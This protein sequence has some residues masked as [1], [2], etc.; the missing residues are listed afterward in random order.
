MPQASGL[1]SQL[2]LAKESTYGTRVAPTKAYEFDS[3]TFGADY[4]SVQGGGLRAGRTMA[5]ASMS[6]RTTDQAA[7]AFTLQV[8]YKGFG[9]ILDLLHNAV[10]TPVQQAATIA[11]KQTH[12]IGV[13]TGTSLSKSA[14]IQINKPDVTG[15]DRPFDYVGSVVTQ[16]ELA[17]SVGGILSSTVTCDARQ[18]MTDQTLAVPSYATGNN[19][20]SFREA[21]VMTLDGTNLGTATEFNLSLGRGMK[22]DRFYLGSGGLKAVPIANSLIEGSGTINVDFNDLAALNLY[23]S[24][25]KVPLVVEFVSA[26]DIVAGQKFRLKL[27]MPAVKLTGGGSPAVGGPDVLTQALAYSILDDGTNVPLT[28]ELTTTDTTV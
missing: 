16:F 12:L 8:P 3:E 11:Y 10:I 9:T 22:T 26:D 23:K 17:M 28:I 18:E 5:Q 4:A 13:T 27:T 20:F 25:N 14:T 21:S 7:G 2:V 1:G 19:V 6:K 24:G 15:M